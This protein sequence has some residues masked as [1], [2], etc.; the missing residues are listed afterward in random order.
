MFCKNCGT[1]IDNNSKF[2]NHCGASLIKAVAPTNNEQIVSPQTVKKLE[3]VFG[4]NLSKP[5]IGGFLVWVLIHLILLLTNWKGSDSANEYFWPFSKRAE[6]EDYDFTEFLLYT[7]VPL[8]VLVIINL[9]KEPQQKKQL[10]LEQ[11]YDLSFEKDTTP[12]M[13]GLFILLIS[14]VLYFISGSGDRQEYEKA[15]QTRAILSVISLF[16]RIGITVWVVNIAKKLNRDTV[17]W[18]F[19]TFFFPSIALIII[20]QKRKLK[21]TNNL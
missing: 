7:V 12:T 6:L 20:G 18:G 8:I 3:T 14:L 21:Q 15:A 17:G 1:Q 11:K 4:V 13:V 9:F 5:A 2:C 19:L 10:A 16:L